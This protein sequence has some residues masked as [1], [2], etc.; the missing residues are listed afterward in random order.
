VR[1]IL[2]A[3]FFL[4]S[5][6]AFA[7]DSV[8]VDL[9]QTWLMMDDGKLVPHSGEGRVAYVNLAELGAGVIHLAGRQPFSILLNNR[10]LANGINQFKMPLNQTSNQ[11][12]LLT[13]Y[14]SAGVDHLTVGYISLA[15]E[16]VFEK[17]PARVSNALI[18]IAI[19]VLA[20]FIL[21]IRT[22][23][24]AA[25]E[26]FNF[27]KLFST[28]SGEDSATTLRITSANNVFYYLFCSALIAVNLYVLYTGTA[29]TGLPLGTV[30]AGVVKLLFLAFGVLVIKILLI[31]VLAS[32]FKLT[33]FGPAQFYNYVRL[34]LVSFVF[35]SAVLLVLVMFKADYAV[36]L[37]R[38]SYFIMGMN[39]VFIG[40]TFLKLMARGG[41]TVF[42]LFSY[43]CASEIIP[44]I[45]LLNVYFS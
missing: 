17:K 42:H 25:A 36:W 12:G 16:N 37:M 9:K 5:T 15:K 18:V 32:I 20:S 6:H 19:L 22:N 39:I 10:L 13:V 26:Y 14:S 27:V 23:G 4:I 29:L 11:P 1:I 40:I 30:L 38:L 3:V 41:F 28:R 44:L 24:Q 8:R 31:S 21:L 7:T 45:I 35:C 34:L 33:D 2:S 43:L